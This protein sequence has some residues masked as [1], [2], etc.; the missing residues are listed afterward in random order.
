MQTTL[1][2]N[3]TAKKVSRREFVKGAAVGAG[4][5][6]GA[7]ALAS[8][9]TAAGPTAPG[10]PAKW[11]KEADVVIVGAGGTGIVAAIEAAAAGSSVVVL[12]KAAIVG[13]TTSLSGAVIQA[14]NTEFQRAAGVEGDTPEQHYQ[15]WITASEGQ[16]DPELVRVLADNA[17]GNIQWLVDQGVEYAGVYG[18]GAIPYID[19]ELMV[20][21]IH[22]PGP[23]GSQP[24]AGAAEEYH[25]QIL[26]RVAQEKGAEF[27]LET[28]VL[29]LLRDPEKGVIGVKAESAGEEMYVKAKKAVIL[30]TS[31]FDHNEEMA[32][33]FSLQQLWAI[34]KGIVAPVPTNTGDG[35]KMAMEI[36]ADLAGM[37]GTIGVPS[38][39][40]GGAAAPGIW[41]NKYGQRFV[42]EAAHY[43]YACRAVFEEELHIAWAIFDEKVKQAGGTALGWS[44][45]LSEEISSAKVKTGDTLSALAQFLGVNGAEL[46]AT[47]GKWN[48]DAASGEDSLFGKKDGLQALDTSPY[49]AAQMSEWNLGAQGGVRI[50]TSAQVLDVHGEVIP[51]LYAGGMVAGGIIGPYYPGSGTA[52]AITVCFGRIAGQNAAAEENWS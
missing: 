32:R 41:V 1:E 44:E 15:Y 21:R 6:T 3:M 2:G 18:V 22:I 29:A 40:I 33:A 5:L 35:I 30:A 11:D 51:R 20:S 26:Y 46:E 9:G 48:E 39:G 37:G 31:S 10:I 36:G 19:P 12:E 50:N 34:E 45:D 14:S 16:A 25:V 52:V 38:P 49:Y 27:L 7:G 47:V 24:A 4:L 43:A 23:P 13:G 17:P 28:P 8:C 42:N